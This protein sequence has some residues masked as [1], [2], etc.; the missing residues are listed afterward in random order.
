MDSR[1]RTYAILIGITL[2]TLPCYCLG[3]IA[4]IS[5]QDPSPTLPP[6]IITATSLATV[7]GVEATFTPSH[8]PISTRPIGLTTVTLPS[9]PDQFVTET[10]FPTLTPSIT[11]SLPPTDTSTPTATPSATASATATSTPSSTA[12]EQATATSTMTITPSFTPTASPT[13]V[14]TDTPTATPPIVDT[15]TPTPTASPTPIP[16]TPTE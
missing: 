15:A 2:L 4:Y 7:E 5:E 9:T 6:A 3:I 13:T 8:T 11:P 1:R 12:T 16:E 14:V 10:R